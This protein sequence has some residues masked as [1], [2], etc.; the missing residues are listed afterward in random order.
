VLE[1]I[2]EAWANGGVAGLSDAG[3]GLSDGGAG[4]VAVVVPP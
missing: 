2:V 3:A 4:A 1:D